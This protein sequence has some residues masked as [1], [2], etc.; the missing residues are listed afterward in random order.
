MERVE[1]IIEEISFFACQEDLSSPGFIEEGSLGGPDNSKKDRVD[2]KP[3]E[4]ALLNIIPY[5][6][7]TL[8]EIVYLS[9]MPLFQVN[10]L[11]LELELKG[12]IKQLP[13]KYFVRN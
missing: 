3:E 2:L 1:D 4:K 6:P 9:E 7:L 11:L 8:E 10:A 5:E 13:G 12:V